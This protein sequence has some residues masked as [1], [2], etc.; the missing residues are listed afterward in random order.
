MSIDRTALVER[1]IATWNETDPAR[2]RALIAATWTEDALY[3]D[4]LMRGEGQAGI[5]AMI[6]A[7]QQRFP[8]HRFRSTGALD[9]HNDRIRFGWS[10]GPQDGPALAAGLDVGVVAGDG[11]LQSITGF[12][13]AMPE[14]A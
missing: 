12:I 6:A 13:D 7:V 14:A 2:R 10:L 9:A 11:R 3:L 8:G 1:Y 5:D 4:P